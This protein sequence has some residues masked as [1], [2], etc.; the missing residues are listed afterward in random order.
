MA[1]IRMIVRPVYFRRL[2]SLGLIAAGLYLPLHGRPETL[3]QAREDQAQTNLELKIIR[4]SNNVRHTNDQPT[5]TKL[6]NLMLDGVSWPNITI[7]SALADLEARSQETD[8]RPV[9]IRFLVQLPQNSEQPDVLGRTVQRNVCI[10]IQKRISFFDA[11]AVLSEQT[12]L[13]FVV[14]KG[15]VLFRQWQPDDFIWL[16]LDE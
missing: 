8:P 3:E 16:N 6:G 1:E 10:V 11:V 9:D 5:I 4:Q 12:N 13:S 14:H 7:K 2:F 15:Q